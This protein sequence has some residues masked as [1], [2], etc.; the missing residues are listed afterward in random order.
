MYSHIKQLYM[1]CGLPGVELMQAVCN[2]CEWLRDEFTA[3]PTCFLLHSEIINVTVICIRLGSAELIWCQ[4]WEKKLYFD[5][6]RA[7]NETWPDLFN[8]FFVD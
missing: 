2:M 6:E 5:V 4:W 8:M 1:A 3:F 7:E